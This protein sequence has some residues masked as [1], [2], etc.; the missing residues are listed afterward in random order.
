MSVDMHQA[1]VSGPSRLYLAPG[2]KHA[3]AYSSN[4]IEYEN[5][6]AAFLAEI[7]V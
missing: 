5:Q 4:P 1:R 2:A 7:G 3:E 6:V